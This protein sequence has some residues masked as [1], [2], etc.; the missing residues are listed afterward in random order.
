MD[1]IQIPS[2]DNVGCGTFESLTDHFVRQQPLPAVPRRPKHTARAPQTRQVR[3][4]QERCGIKKDF[5]TASLRVSFSLSL[6]MTSVLLAE[7]KISFCPPDEIRPRPQLFPPILSKRRSSAAPF[8]GPAAWE[9]VE[10][11]SLRVFPN[12]WRIIL[13]A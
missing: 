3:R 12:F 13:L 6:S 8:R 7:A 2:H 10:P 1:S 9:C 11:A 5:F 4:R